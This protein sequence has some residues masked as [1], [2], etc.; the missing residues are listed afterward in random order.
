MGWDGNR[1][2]TNGVNER[3]DAHMQSLSL[4]VTTALVAGG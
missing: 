2:V 3:N 4:E 1:F